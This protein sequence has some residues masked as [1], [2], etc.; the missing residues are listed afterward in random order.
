MIQGPSRNQNHILTEGWSNSDSEASYV[1]QWP[2][3]PKT[4][5]QYHTGRGCLSC[6]RFA[7][8]NAD[9]GLCCNQESRH[10]TET[11]FEH[12][13]CPWFCIRR[14]EGEKDAGGRTKPF[15]NR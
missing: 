5:E 10:F 8:L 6:S 1:H 11:V 13:T 4:A 12:F 14:S 15:G 3:E 2:G 7:T 9:W